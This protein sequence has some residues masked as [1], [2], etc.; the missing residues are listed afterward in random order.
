M[1]KIFLVAALFTATTFA[2]AQTKTTEAYSAVEASRSMS[3]N[4][5][6]NE[7]Q[8]VQIKALNNVKQERYRDIDALYAND[9]EMRQQKLDAL[10]A[11]MDME[12][13]KVLKADQYQT[14]LELEGRSSASY[15][16]MG[17]SVSPETDQMNMSQPD[18]VIIG[19]GQTDPAAGTKTDMK[20]KSG[21]TKMK[22]E[23]GKT[24]MESGN[25]EAKTKTNA[26]ESKSKMKRADGSQVKEESD[27]DR[28]KYQDSK[29]NSKVKSKDDKLKME[30]KNGKIKV[31]DDKVK[32][33]SR[34]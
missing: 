22:S 34:D 14:Y 8:Y 25:T 19:S 16:T 7:G 6:L 9:P 29:D 15:Q 4:L 1:K 33:K 13:Q 24:K 12:Y 32:I 17:G 27:K 3:E 11:E 26:S 18:A 23:P 2:F 21:D 30:D 5:M 10:N 31:E 20:V 28:Y